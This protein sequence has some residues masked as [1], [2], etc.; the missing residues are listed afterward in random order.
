MTNRPLIKHHPPWLI[1][2]AFFSFPSS[3]L[4]TFPAST[5]CLH[6]RRDRR[7]E[8]ETLNCWCH[9]LLQ[10]CQLCLHVSHPIGHCRW[11]RRGWRIW[12]RRFGALTKCFREVDES[13]G[14]VRDVVAQVPEDRCQMC[15]DRSVKMERIRHGCQ[16]RDHLGN[17]ETIEGTVDVLES[18]V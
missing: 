8:H 16:R 7:H 3:L 18:G 10:I 6:R 9:L 11:N 4:A 17:F 15:R 12:R 13:A 1:S 5:R 14:I 2:G